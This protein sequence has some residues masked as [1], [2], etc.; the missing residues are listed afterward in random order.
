MK[1][2]WMLIGWV[3]IWLAFALVL[4]GGDRAW[5]APFLD[6][7]PRNW[8]CLFGALCGAFVLLNRR[9]EL[10]DARAH[11]LVVSSWAMALACTTPTQGLWALALPLTTILWLGILALKGWQLIFMKEGRP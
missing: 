1:K 4:A 2:D 3:T 5:A 7:G 9:P 8:L 6:E 11:A 10:S